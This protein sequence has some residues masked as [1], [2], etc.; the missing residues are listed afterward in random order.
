MAGFCI[1]L[2][3]NLSFAM[4]AKDSLIQINV[5]HGDF[6][7]DEWISRELADQ[8][9]LEHGH[10]ISPKSEVFR[11]IEIERAKRVFARGRDVIAEAKKKLAKAKRIVSEVEKR[12]NEAEK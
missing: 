6:I 3:S 1:S 8:Y 9:N 5:D 11:L 12:I 10:Y 4:Q 7:T 2:P